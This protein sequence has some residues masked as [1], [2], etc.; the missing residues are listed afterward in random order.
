MNPE[1]IEAA[2]KAA[3]GDNWDEADDQWKAAYR[4]EARIHLEAAAPYLIREARAAE[5]EAA[6]DELDADASHSSY[7]DSEEVTQGQLDA[8]EWLRARAA[9]IR[10]SE[11]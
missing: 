5:L 2:A 3:W 11:A 4:Q 8:A 9:A 7:S 10:A 6:A 1:A